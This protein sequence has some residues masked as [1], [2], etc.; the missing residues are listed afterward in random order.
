MVQAAL[1]SMPEGCMGVFPALSGF[2][3]IGRM[4]MKKKKKG[5]I[6]RMKCPY[7]G[8][9]VIYRSADGIYKENSKR[10]MLYVCSRYPVCDAYV[11]IHQGTRIP[12]GTPANGEL[13]ALRVQAHRE[14]DLLHT[15]GIMTRSQA[16][17]WLAKLVGLPEKEAHIG[18][19]G[20]YNCKRIIEKSRE[21]LE[22]QGIEI[23]VA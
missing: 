10:E 11:R 14:F 4:V 16:Y 1:R 5:D 21:F 3:H 7:C 13:R 9:T 8:S 15:S 17:R 12:M 23:P 6:A 2:F 18:N 19:M 22:K 20:E